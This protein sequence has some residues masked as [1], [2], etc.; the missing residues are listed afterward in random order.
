MQ[1]IDGLIYAEESPPA[2]PTRP[3]REDILSLLL[4]AR[5]ADDSSAGL[6]DTKLHDE[7]QTLLF[8]GHETTGIALAWASYWLHRDPTALK[9][10]RSEI[11][12][13]GDDPEPDAIAKLPFLDAVCNRPAPAP[14]SPPT[15]PACSPA[16]W[17]SPA[18]ASHPPRSR[19]RRHHNPPPQRGALP[20]AREVPPERFLN[21]RFS[22]FE[23]TPFG[24]GH[25][26]CTG[27]A[28][29]DLQAEDRPRH[30]PPRGPPRAR[31]TRRGPPRPPQRRPRPRH[32]RPHAHARA[33]D[34][35]RLSAHRRPHPQREH[36]Q[37][38]R[39]PNHGD[40]RVD[41]SS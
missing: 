20:R 5:V 12:S 22:P 30:L 29:R 4:S 28:F 17:S 35:R 25:R 8:A 32:R 23:Y 3:T 11:D 40:I 26:R 15:S 16:P 39:T 18:P 7:L 13:L 41:E 19:Q 14:R 36:H 31:R 24:G 2:G 1:T 33:T 37:P 27:A 34:P 10:L 38:R 9:R 6:S 21:R